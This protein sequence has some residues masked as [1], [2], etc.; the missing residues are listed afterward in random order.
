MAPACTI[1]ANP[2][3]CLFQEPGWRSDLLPASK[4]ALEA[5][6]RCHDSVGEISNVGNQAYGRKDYA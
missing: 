5:T 6:L 1:W 4:V 3:N 2:V